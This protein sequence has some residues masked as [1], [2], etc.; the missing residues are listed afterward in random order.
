MSTPSRIATV[1]SREIF[2]FD[3]LLPA[4]EVAV[5]ARAIPQAAFTRSESAR[6]DSDVRHWVCEMPL[7]NLPRTSLW[8]ATEQ[9][10]SELRPQERYRPYRVY[11]NFSSFGDLLLTHVD[12]L[13]NARELTA[14]WYLCDRWDAEW[15]GETLFY[16]DGNDAQ[17]AVSPRPGRLLLFDGAIRHAGKPPNRNCPVGRYTFAIKLRRV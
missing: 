13:P 16:D 15:G 8:H 9:V 10:V 12:A 14:L 7:E 11:T 1:G 5:Y 17:V 6:P 4:E 2:V 3:G